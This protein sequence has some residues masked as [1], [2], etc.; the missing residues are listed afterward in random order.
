MKSYGVKN[1]K[2]KIIL[3]FIVFFSLHFCIRC[4]STAFTS[5]FSFDGAIIAQVA[6]NVAEKFKFKT[7]YW[8]EQFYVPVTGVPVIF[9]VALFFKIFGKSFS[10]GLMVN[11]IYM[12]LLFFSFIYF[13][14]RCIKLDVFF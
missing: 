9:P 3:L 11:A 14:K 13:L 10:S 1:L 2:D 4:I 12:I 6:K 5:P 7:D 8:N